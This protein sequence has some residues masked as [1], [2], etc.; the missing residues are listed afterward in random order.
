MT[1]TSLACRHCHR[2]DGLVVRE[3]YEFPVETDGTAYKDTGTPYQE[4]WCSRCDHNLSDILGVEY[5]EEGFVVTV[6]GL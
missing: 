3:T 1:H 5:T 4:V 2:D 6:A